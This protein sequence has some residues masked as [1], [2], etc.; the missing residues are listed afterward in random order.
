VTSVLTVKGRVDVIG[1]GIDEDGAGVAVGHCHVVE[2]GPVHGLLGANDDDNEHDST[3]DDNG[4]D[5][6]TRDGTSNSTNVQATNQAAVSAVVGPNAQAASDVGV[7]VGN[8]VAIVTRAV[9]GAGRSGNGDG[10]VAQL[11]GG[12]EVRTGGV[13]VNA[14]LGLARRWAPTTGEGIAG[15]EEAGSAGL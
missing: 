9:V 10:K 6:T 2:H 12:G 7:R 11:V 8:A 1:V 13:D 5:D 14:S 15:V 4:S 3:D